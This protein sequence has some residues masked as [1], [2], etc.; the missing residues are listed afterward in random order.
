M[1]LELNVRHGVVNDAVREAVI[2]KFQR[3]DRKLS[4]DVSIEVTLDRERN[5]RIVD[6]HVIEAEVRQKSLHAIGK[7]AGPTYEIAADRVVAVLDRQI[8]R[9]REKKVLEPRRR[10]AQTEQTAKVATGPP[11][12]TDE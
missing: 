2:R 11:P 8:D 7:A 1:K 9:H 3:L 6:D 4:S 10:G 5:P 12:G